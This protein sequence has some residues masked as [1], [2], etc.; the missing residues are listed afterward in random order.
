MKIL[1][2]DATNE[3]LIVE[4]YDMGKPENPVFS[5]K[6]YFPR[7]SSF[8]LVKEIEIALEKSNFEKPDL[9]VACKGP[10]SF[11]G[12]RICVATARNLAQIWKVPL[13]GVNSIE[14]YS[15]YYFEERNSPSIV[16]IEGGQNKYFAGKFDQ[17]GF[18][19]CF[20]IT[21]EEVS[22]IFPDWKSNS[23]MYS[24]HGKFENSIDMNSDIPGA[25][26]LLKDFSGKNFA[27]EIFNYKNTKPNYM[28]GT[29]AKEKK[30]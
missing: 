7:E 24:V 23:E 20:D 4:T 25:M 5:L 29:Y 26:F 27:D 11:T 14:F 9:I 15:R 28:R 3:W 6:G 10:G 2:L 8:R 18:Q 13:A 1:F 30:K 16:L 12:I 21:K 19:G 22:E 17:N